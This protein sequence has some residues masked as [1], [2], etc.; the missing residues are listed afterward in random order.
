MYFYK[1][2]LHFEKKQ[3]AKKFTKQK[4]NKKKKE[5]NNESH[6]LHMKHL[7]YTHY[8]QPHKNVIHIKKKNKKIKCITAI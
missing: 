4:N 3:K 7:Y 2:I 6:T 5:T 1:L 8:I